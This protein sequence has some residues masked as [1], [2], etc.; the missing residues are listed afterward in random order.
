MTMTTYEEIKQEIKQEITN[1]ESLEDIKDRAHELVEN[2]VPVYNN[3]VIEE[4]QTMPNEYD[5]RGGAELGHTSE[6]SKGTNIINLMMLDLSLYYGDL[7][8]LVIED[9][10]EE[11]ESVE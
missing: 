1:G 9:L 4:W 11:L 10:E 6:D 7:V 2:Y 5:N 3:H 8:A